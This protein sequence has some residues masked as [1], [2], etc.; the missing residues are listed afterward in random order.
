MPLT[1]SPPLLILGTQQEYI[2]RIRSEYDGV[3]IQLPEGA[4]TK[5][6]LNRDKDCEHFICG[7]GKVKVNPA[8]AQRILWIRFVLENS[9]VRVVKKNLKNGNIIFYCSELNYIVIC[10]Q[11]SGRSLKCFTQYMLSADDCK[12]FSDAS[13]YCDHIL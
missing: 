7:K 3:E 13:L 2:D 6:Y 4:T 1:E 10:S 11:L 5:F 12:K 9:H 8:R